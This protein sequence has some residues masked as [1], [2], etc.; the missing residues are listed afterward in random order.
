[1]ASSGV[2]HPRVLRGLWFI[3][4]GHVGQFG[5]TDGARIGALGE[6]LAQ[7]TVGVFPGTALRGSVRIAEPDAD[8]QAVGQFRVAG[9]LAAAV[10]LQALSLSESV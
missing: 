6:E 4:A 5:L 7:Q 3:K 1:M 2:F 9:H 10:L 8:L